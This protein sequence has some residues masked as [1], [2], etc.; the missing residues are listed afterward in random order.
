MLLEIDYAHYEE[1]IG[2]YAGQDKDERDMVSIK[3]GW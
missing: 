3:I 1:E 2:A